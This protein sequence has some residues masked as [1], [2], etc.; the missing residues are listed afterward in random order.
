LIWLDDDQ[1]LDQ[2]MILNFGYLS[3]QALTHPLPP[4]IDNPNGTFKSTDEQ[5]VLLCL[6]VLSVFS[7]RFM[8][9]K[10][11]AQVHELAT[12]CVTTMDDDDKDGNPRGNGGQ[13]MKMRCIDLICL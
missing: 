4:I 11:K 12:L 5:F 3:S 1:I 7:H 8:T 6:E 9:E 2:R 13:K 10:K